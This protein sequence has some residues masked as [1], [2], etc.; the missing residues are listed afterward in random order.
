VHAAEQQRLRELGIAPLCLYLPCLILFYAISRVSFEEFAPP[1]Q[2]MQYRYLLPHFLFA[3][4]AIAIGSAELMRKS[5]RARSLGIATAG[6]A[7]ATSLWMLP[8][9]VPNDAQLGAGLRYPGF[10]IDYYPQLALREA[11]LIP[12]VDGRR[13]DR[14]KVARELDGLPN[15]IA[16]EAW[17]GVGHRLGLLE[18][19]PPANRTDPPDYERALTSLFE[20]HPERFTIDLARGVGSWLRRRAASDPEACAALATLLGPRLEGQCPALAAY[21]VEGAC[22]D[23]GQQLASATTRSLEMNDRVGEQVPPPWR[24][25]LRRGEGLAVGRLLLRGIASDVAA[26]L[27]WSARVP[28]QDRGDLWFGIGWGLVDGGGDFTLAPESLRFATR[29]ERPFLALG[30]GAALRHVWGATEAVSRAAA[31]RNRLDPADQVALD[32]GLEWPQYP[33]P[34][35][36]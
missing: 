12:P 9:I 10:G 6:A 27:A 15:G 24:G 7:L 13:V 14:R 2:V 19:W 31:L 22:L 8:I 18:V 29:G 16:N 25:A 30:A 17:F 36:L 20:D 23:F 32:R 21:L 34:L 4:M 1:L 11:L 26:A 28:E 33:D 3:V 5:G 35:E